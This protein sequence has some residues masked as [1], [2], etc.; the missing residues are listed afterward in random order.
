MSRTYSKEQRKTN[1]EFRKLRQRKRSIT[2][3]EYDE[4]DRQHFPKFMLKNE[5]EKSKWQGR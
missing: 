5:H 4:Q 3:F 1:K 2:V